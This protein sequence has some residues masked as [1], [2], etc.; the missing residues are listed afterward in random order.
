[1]GLQYL[2]F[3]I[4]AVTLSHSI[5]I[6]QGAWIHGGLHTHSSSCLL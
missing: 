6:E 5:A 3:Q 2:L 4:V 1:M